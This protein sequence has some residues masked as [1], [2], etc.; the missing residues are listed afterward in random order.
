[1]TVLFSLAPTRADS[2]LHSN[3]HTR[4]FHSSLTKSTKKERESSLTNKKQNTHLPH[5]KPWHYLLSSLHH[6][7][8]APEPETTPPP[9]RLKLKTKLV[10]KTCSYRFQVSQIKQVIASMYVIHIQFDTLLHRTRVHISFC[11]KKLYKKIFF[12]NSPL[13]PLSSGPLREAWVLEVPAQ[14]LSCF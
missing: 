5:Q 4:P 10:R 14:Y 8:P 13:P 6:L 12:L 3:T 2:L 1:M 7:S 11:V 9:Q